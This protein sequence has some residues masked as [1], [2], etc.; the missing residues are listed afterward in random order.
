MQIRKIEVSGKIA[1]LWT[2]IGNHYETPGILPLEIALIR[3]HSER[4]K[5][6][7]SYIEHVDK[8]E[9]KIGNH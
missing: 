2:K 3:L 7:I 8:E 4:A 9:Y 5:G 6:F 1:R